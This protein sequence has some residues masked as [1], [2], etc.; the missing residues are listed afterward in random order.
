MHLVV[1][2]IES[3]NHDTASVSDRFLHM[4]CAVYTQAGASRLSLCVIDVHV[5]PVCIT[6]YDEEAQ[7]NEPKNVCP[8][9]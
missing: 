9:D 7:E 5:L 1:V 6:A 2:T 3:L 4:G 8:V